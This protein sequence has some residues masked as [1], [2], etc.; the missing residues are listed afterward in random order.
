MKPQ[1]RLKEKIH[2]LPDTPIDIKLFDALYK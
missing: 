2:F 1:R